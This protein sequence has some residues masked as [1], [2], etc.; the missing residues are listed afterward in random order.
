MI[1]LDLQA[2]IINSLSH[3]SFLS[4]QKKPYIFLLNLFSLAELQFMTVKILT[5]PL[6]NGH[7]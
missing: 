5:N 1:F 3:I 7:M 4:P 2:F 6:P